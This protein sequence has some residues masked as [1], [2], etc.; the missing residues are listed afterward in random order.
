MFANGNLDEFASS[1]G[2]TV[3]DRPVVNRTGLTGRYDLTLNWRP[4]EFQSNNFGATL[5]DPPANDSRPD[6]FTAFQQQ[7]GLKLESAKGPVD[8]VVIDHAEH[9]SEN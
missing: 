9:P 4:D 5:P 8:I 6:V 2:I 3:M 1:F 7:L